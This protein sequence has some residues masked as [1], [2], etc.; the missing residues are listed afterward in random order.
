MYRRHN[1]KNLAFVAAASVAAQL[2]GMQ[3]APATGT[4]GTPT[5]DAL[6]AKG[7]AELTAGKVDNAV[8]DLTQAA[9]M[10]G[11]NVA[12]LWRKRRKYGLD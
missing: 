3:M 11:I 6:V 4:A 10:L 1:F 8:K 2:I 9:D 7:S 12:T 5:A